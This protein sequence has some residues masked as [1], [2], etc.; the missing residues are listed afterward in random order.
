MITIGKRRT[1]E[2]YVEE[3]ACINP[4]ICVIEKYNGVGKHILHKCKICDHEWN[5]TP[6]NMLHGNQCPKCSLNKRTKTHETFCKEMETINN[7]IKILSR[8]QNAK[9]KV[10]CECKMCGNRWNASPDSLLQGCGCPKCANTVVSQ[11][12]AKDDDY[13]YSHLPEKIKNN[14]KIKS[15]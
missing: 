7:S 14:I 4:N 13:F 2:E 10:E 12:L 9:T 5:A 3:L 11:K 15:K 1:H 8:Y 6:N